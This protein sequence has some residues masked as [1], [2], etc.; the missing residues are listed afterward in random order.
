M[1]LKET[2]VSLIA[3]NIHA[4][5]LPYPTDCIRSRSANKLTANAPRPIS[6]VAITAQR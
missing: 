2:A 1:V 4:V 3:G 5:A 6:A